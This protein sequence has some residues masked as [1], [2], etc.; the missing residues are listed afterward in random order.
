MIGVIDYG[1]GNVRA[2]LNIYKRLDIAAKPVSEPTDIEE[3]ERLILPGV[4][5]FDWAMGTLEKSGLLGSVEEAVIKEKKPLL[6]IC[7][8]MHMLAEGSDEGQ[9]RGLGWIKGRVRHLGLKEG[10]PLPH[11]GWNKIEPEAENFPLFSGLGHDLR[12]YF[13]HSYYFD[14][15]NAG[16]VVA[17]TDYGRKFC[18]AVARGHIMGVQFHPEK[19]HR[20]GIGL[21]KNF[22]QY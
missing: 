12:F 5:A 1:V 8:G 19:S 14:P 13:L 20:F 9:E 4:G 10:L 15:E 18:S 2:F 21:L 17:R 7:I 3:V 11:M 6:C 22:A 16:E